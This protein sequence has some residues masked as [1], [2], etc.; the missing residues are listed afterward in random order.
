MTNPNPNQLTQDKN[1]PKTHRHALVIGG[2]IAGLTAARVLSD[3][4][5][6]VTIIER[7][8]LPEQPAFRKGVPQGRHPH[9]LLLGGL[10][11]LEQQF[12]G[13]TDELHTAGAVPFN[14]GSEARL[15]L[16][17]Q[18]RVRYH[19]AYTVLAVTRPLLEET[20]RHRLVANPR[21][22]FLPGLEAIGLCTDTA[23]T[24][25]TGVQLRQRNGAAWQIEA[26]LVVAADGR[27]SRA[28][29]WLTALGFPTPHETVVDAHP[30]YA[31]RFYRLPESVRYDWK[32]MFLQPLA[33]DQQRGALLLKVEDDQW[34][35]TLIGMA[36]DH[37]PT[38]EAGFVA[39]ARSLIEPDVF[40]F[41][42]SAE[43][44]SPIWGYR[45]MENRLRH[46]E[47]LPRYLENFLVCGDAAYAFNPAYGQGMSV[48]AIASMKLDDCLRQQQ[49]DLTG[50]AA[51]FQKAL[52]TLIDAPWQL[53]TGQDR[54]WQ[55]GPEAKTDHMT[56]LVQGYIRRVL[57]TM[58]VDPVVAE[59]FLA[60]Q[61]L[62]APP[63]RL[64][65]PDVLWRTLKPR[66]R[67]AD[68][69]GSLS[70]DFAGSATADMLA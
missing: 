43:P 57:G 22:T 10:R 28:T 4:F 18:W 50:L 53:A 13:I 39:Y 59:A 6:R 30:G 63:T 54:D 60:V 23:N 34:Q 55:D 69:S 17:G 12:P 9:V 66:R 62:L 1:A 61:Q 33:P 5:D 20:I 49:G 11:V 47:A 67:V 26:D 8:L 51:R 52:T 27:G 68:Q 21:I 38:D 15:H 46:Y 29:E 56:R 7:D 16:L 2:S 24:R 70:A 58:M 48:A 44:A 31:T 32:A 25:A 42:Q 40:N 19:S 3:H 64:F 41:V 14:L 37:P 45:R 36:G 65:Y 35:L